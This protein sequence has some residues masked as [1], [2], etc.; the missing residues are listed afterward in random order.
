MARRQ[1]RLGRRLEGTHW[2][3]CDAT[4]KRFT[5]PTYCRLAVGLDYL[6][7]CPVR[8][9]RHGGGAEAMSATVSVETPQEQ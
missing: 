9:I 6:D 3:S 7:A 1:P 4:H 2:L 5:G 8:G